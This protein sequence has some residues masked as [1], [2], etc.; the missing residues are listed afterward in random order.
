MDADTQAVAT[1]ETTGTD[2]AQD[3]TT[4]PTTADNTV[5]NLPDW[6][7]DLLKDLRQE[8]AKHRTAKKSAEAE[9]KKAEEARLIEEGKVNELYETAKAELEEAR[10]Q[11]VDAEHRRIKANIAHKH[12]LPDV[13]ISRLRGD[14]EEE[15]E[16]DAQLLLEAMPAPEQPKPSVS[17]T[18]AN[19]GQNTITPTAP[20]TE[21]AIN[22]QAA[23]LGVNPK[24]L[25]QYLETT[26]S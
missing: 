5:Q 10:Q 22:E 17:G 12:N 2:G 24:L 14:T 7:Q 8:N 18:D 9:V 6:A 3:A 4:E 20:P 21:M 11:A 26:R 23:R 19:A 1:E 13:L 16:T 25:K 15:M